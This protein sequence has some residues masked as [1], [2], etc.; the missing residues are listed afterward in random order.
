MSSSEAPHV[1]WRVNYPSV[2]DLEITLPESLGHMLQERVLETPD[3]EALVFFEHRQQLTYRELSE[4]VRSVAAG[5][6]ARGV[7]KGT[8]V[9][10]MMPN[11]IE[12]PVTWLAL[13]WIGAV[14]VQLNPRNTGHE[15][16]YALNDADV[17]LL[18]IDE[19][20]V[21]AFEAMRKRPKRLLDAHVFVTG[22]AYESQSYE[23][24]QILASSEPLDERP[25]SDVTQHDLVA[26]L[27][28]SGTTGFPKG[29]MLDHR[30]WLQLARVTLYGQGGH[31]PRNVLIYEP[32]FYMAAIYVLLATLLANATGYCAAKPSLSKLLDW[33]ENYQIDYC[34]YPAPAV[35]G[36]ENVPREKGRSL[37][38]VHAW[39][40]HGDAP[41]RLEKHFDVVARSGYGMTEIGRGM[42]VPVDRPDMAESGAVGVVAPWREVRIVDADGNDL[43]DGEVGELWTAGPGQLQGYYRNPDANAEAF[44]G[45]W[46]RTGDLMR[47]DSTGVY[48]LIGRMKDMIKRSGE[49]ISCAEVEGCLCELAGVLRAAVVAVPDEIRDEEVKAYVELEEGVERNEISPEKIV[50][51]CVEHLAS[52]KIP[53]YIAYVDSFPMTAANDKIAKPKL[54]AD[55]EDLRVDAYDRVDDVWR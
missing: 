31:H 2:D 4:C 40:F 39:Y 55:V 45:R 46:F 23:S 47:R 9:A 22:A 16:D 14:A 24:W 50:S 15:L 30:Y 3:R 6:Q 20:C 5:L 8:H 32:M 12:F 34:S 48:F 17:D 29:C 1:S 27:Y 19:S 42:I 41:A 43:P 36:I 18:I 7:R 49:N 26:I 10:I 28:T 54:L 11:R 37:K 52:F 21:P 25:R 51:H 13:A 38:W 44:R 35:V 53:R 33:I